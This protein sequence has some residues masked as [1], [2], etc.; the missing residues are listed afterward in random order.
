MC[1]P[2]FLIW[3]LAGLVLLV[4]ACAVPVAVPVTEQSPKATAEESAFSDA[5]FDRLLAC[6]EENFP[7][8][9]YFTNDLLPNVGAAWEPM[10]CESVD[11]VR[12]GMSWILN[13]GGAPG[14][15]Q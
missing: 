15:T 1:S 14:T 10:D 8:E 9:S 11:Q 13:D 5:E 2:K 12:V 3:L 4:S 7:A 6:V